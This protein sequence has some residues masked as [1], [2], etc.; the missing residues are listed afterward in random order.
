MLGAALG[1]LFGV[2]LQHFV[3]QGL[4]GGLAFFNRRGHCISHK[5]RM[6]SPDPAAARRPSP[7]IRQAVSSAA[8][9]P[10][11]DSSTCTMM[12]FSISRSSS[13][14]IVIGVGTTP[15]PPL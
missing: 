15:L 3:D 1:H 2:G 10:T 12:P 14:S 4:V 11:C 5:W 8:V 7:G 6:S 9:L 13:W